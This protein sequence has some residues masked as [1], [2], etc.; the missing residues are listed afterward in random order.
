VKKPARTRAAS[1]GFET[2]DAAPRAV[3][4]SGLGLLLGTAFCGLLVIGLLALLPTPARPAKPALETVSEVPPSPRLE[5]DGRMN[6]AAVES[7]AAARLTGYAWV[8]RSAGT[9]RIPIERAME[10]LA[11]QGWSKP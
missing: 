5:I 11:K 3:V 1:A 7:A 9:A 10:L 6:R 4:Y 2:C 8:D